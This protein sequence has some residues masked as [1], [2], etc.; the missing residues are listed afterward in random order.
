VTN[1]IDGAGLF[2]GV[3]KHLQNLRQDCP[4]VLVATHFHDVFDA[5]F[6]DHKSPLV[7]YVHMQIMMTSAQGH[8]I[9]SQSGTDTSTD[10]TDVALNMTDPDRLRGQIT[11]LYR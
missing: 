9:E 7:G 11:Y 8:L 10:D 2:C 1:F 4:K 5:S 6:L 3:I